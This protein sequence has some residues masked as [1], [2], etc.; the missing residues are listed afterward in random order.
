M[1]KNT[2]GNEK[3]LGEI[4]REMAALGPVL[5][6]DMSAK[7][8]Q[9]CSYLE[10]RRKNMEYG[11]LR[12]LG[13][14]IGSGHIESGCKSIVGA[15]CKQAGMHWRHR[16]AAYVSAIRAAIRSNNFIEA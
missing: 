2:A 13:Y 1:K 10:E 3:R 14:L 16:N 4:R 5:F 6:G 12:K 7:A 8:S 15:R 9:A 11:R